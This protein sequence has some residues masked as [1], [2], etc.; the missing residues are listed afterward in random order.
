MHSYENISWNIFICEYLKVPYF[1]GGLIL[2][3]LS[4]QKLLSENFIA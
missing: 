3:K 4:M 2:Q 1:A